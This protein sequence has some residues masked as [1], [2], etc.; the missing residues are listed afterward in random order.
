MLARCLEPSNPA[1]AYYKGRGITVCDR[2]R[3]GDDGKTG[4]ECFL[5]DMGER[6]SLAHSLDRIDN[7]GSY[8]PGNVRWATKTEQA[9][10]RI[11]NT[12]VELNGERMTLAEACRRSGVPKDRAR[13]RIRSGW[14][15]DAIFAAGNFRGQRM[16]F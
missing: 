6:P 11:T 12:I 14:P 5:D 13:S 4:F 10:N 7:N 15:M 8:E 1:H 3:F 9:N 16:S 2:W